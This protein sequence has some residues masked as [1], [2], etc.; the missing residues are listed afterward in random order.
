MKRLRKYFIIILFLAI[1]VGY[2]LWDIRQAKDMASDACSK[3][4][5]GMSLDE[6]FSEFPQ[7]DYRIILNDTECILV[8]KGGMGRYQCVIFHEGRI[9]TGSK[10]GFL[11]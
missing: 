8:P 4:V 7:K 6:Y 3:A 1:P 10:T 11:D 5:K 9:I 2:V